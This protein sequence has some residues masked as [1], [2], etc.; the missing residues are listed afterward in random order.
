MVAQLVTFLTAGNYTVS[1]SCQLDDNEM[2]D[3]L[4]FDGTQNVTVEAST[5]AQ[6]ETIPLAP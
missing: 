5:E 2:S 6:A 1:C 4:E 3:A